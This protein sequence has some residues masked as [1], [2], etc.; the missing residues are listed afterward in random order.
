MAH[1]N[2]RSGCSNKGDAKLFAQLPRQPRQAFLTRLKFSAR[3]L[4]PARHVLTRRPLRDQH[5]AGRID[6]RGRDNMNHRPGTAR[7]HGPARLSD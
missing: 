2:Q 7:T 5:A 3:E 4:P 1:A 6:H